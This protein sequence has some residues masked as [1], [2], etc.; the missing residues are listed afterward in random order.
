MSLL[1]LLQGPSYDRVL[2]DA[3]RSAVER[4]GPADFA[5][6]VVTAHMAAEIVT[7]Q[8]FGALLEHRRVGE[9]D[10]ALGDLLP[11]YS[12]GNEKVQAVYEALS[13]DSVGQAPFWQRFKEHAVRRNR[14]IHE[15]RRV[16]AD[17]ARA[18]ITAVEDLASHLRAMV[19]RLGTNGPK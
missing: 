19:A 4:G 10:A 7:E 2:L 12:L 14:V 3:A 13:G 1:L 11:S 6:A 9:L 17:E 5:I 15:R 16:S 8:T 18:S